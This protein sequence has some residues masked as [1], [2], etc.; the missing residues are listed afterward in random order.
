M[1][2]YDYTKLILDGLFKNKGEKQNDGTYNYTSVPIDFV[3]N[4]NK[5]IYL[6][7]LTRL[8]KDDHTAHEDGLFYEEPATEVSGNSTGYRR[9]NIKGRSRIKKEDVLDAEGNPTGQK[10][11]VLILSE[12]KFEVASDDKGNPGKVAYIDSQDQI[13]FPESQVAW[14][15]IEGFGLF[16]NADVNSQTLPFLWG[17]IKGLDAQG[18]EIEGEPVVI[19][20]Y[21]VPVIREGNLKVS[22]G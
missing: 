19:A 15:T 17:P 11:G 7:L 12:V 5:E 14:G 16:D 9:I 4:K 2:N 18:N 22:L 8:P 1:L 20:Q 13:L 3:T 10:R 21:E 6:G